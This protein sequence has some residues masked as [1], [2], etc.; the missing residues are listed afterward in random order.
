MWVVLSLGKTSPVPQNRRFTGPQVRSVAAE[1][2]KIPVGISIPG[3]LSSRPWPSNR[4]DW[5]VPPRLIKF[6]SPSL[7]FSNVTLKLGVSLKTVLQLL[8]DIDI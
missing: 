3:L 8:Y 2:R 7:S 6:I 5:A 4:C 1:K